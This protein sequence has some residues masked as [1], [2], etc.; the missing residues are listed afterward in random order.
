MHFQRFTFS[1]GMAFAVGETV[2]VGNKK[3]VCCSDGLGMI[4]PYLI[5]IGQV[6]V[7]NGSSPVNTAKQ[8]FIGRLIPLRA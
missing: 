6:N 5:F 4:Q 1:N 7:S 3:A 2:S 8:S